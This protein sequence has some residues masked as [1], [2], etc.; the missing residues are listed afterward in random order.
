MAE[1]LWRD[2]AEKLRHRIESEF[3]MGALLPSEQDLATQYGV[4]RNTIRTAIGWLTNHRLVEA[5]PGQGTFVREINPFVTILSAEVGAGPEAES[6]T[7]GTKAAAREIVVEVRKP[8]IGI[9][10]VSE[11]QEAAGLELDTD[12]FVLSRRQERLI[13]SEPWSLQTTFYPL[14][15]ANNGAPALMEATDMPG[16]TVEYL[17]ETLDIKEASWQDTF[18]VRAPSDDETE[19]FKLPT[20]GRV[21]VIQIVR[22]GYDQTQK[23]FRVTSYVYPAD[24][25]QFVMRGGMA[26]PEKPLPTE[27]PVTR[28]PPVTHEQPPAMTESP[29]G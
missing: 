25:N 18:T 20:D 29:D 7:Y 26:P 21:G 9:Q 6:P 13:N 12:A 24:Q 19:F 27:T 23:P 16:G 2:I 10:Q 17:K 15:F 3:P 11:A 5:R 14:S 4:S 22:I 8:R 28:D 1:P